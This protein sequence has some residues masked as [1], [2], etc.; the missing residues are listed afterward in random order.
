MTPIE[1]TDTIVAVT[2][3]LRNR[4][5]GEFRR[6]DRT[7]IDEALCTATMEAWSKKPTYFPKRVALE[8]F[9][10]DTARLRLI[11]YMRKVAIR[12]GAYTPGPRIYDPSTHI[13]RRLDLIK[14]IKRSTHSSMWPMLWNILWYGYTVREAIGFGARYIG[15]E[16]T[17]SAGA[18][19]GQ[20]ARALRRVK[21]RLRDDARMIVP[22][23]HESMSRG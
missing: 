8:I 16:R 7:E 18:L 11:D 20:L 3:Q 21:Q 19:R 2:P 17:E 14:A 6:A 1:F 12:F 9:V 13:D 22:Q 5:S 15:T 4:L 23:A 10:L